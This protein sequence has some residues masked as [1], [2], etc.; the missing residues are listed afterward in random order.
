MKKNTLYQR[1]TI[2]PMEQEHLDEVLAIEALCFSVPWSREAYL[3]LL[4]SH[5]TTLTVVLEQDKVVGYIGLQHVLDTGDIVTIAVHPDWQGQG[6]ATFLLEVAFSQAKKLA[7]EIIFLEVRESNSGARH[8]YKKVGFQESGRRKHY[9]RKP[10]E[11]AIVMYRYIK[12]V[13]ELLAP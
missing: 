3:S 1:L 9:Y 7:L 12:P 5:Y 11:D 8:L 2:K 10:V 4:P 13:E 6:I